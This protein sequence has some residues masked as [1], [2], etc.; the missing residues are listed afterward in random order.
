MSAAARDPDVARRLWLESVRLTG[1]D[2]G[3]L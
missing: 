3:G 2:F 1:E